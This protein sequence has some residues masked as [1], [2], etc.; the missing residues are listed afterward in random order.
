[1]DDGI[2]PL[3]GCA[4]QAS[5]IAGRVAAGLGSRSLFPPVEVGE[6]LAGALLGC[7]VVAVAVS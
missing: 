3:D 7:C 2:V 4:D 5:G 1:M 6:G